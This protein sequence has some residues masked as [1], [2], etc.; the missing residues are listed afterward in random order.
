MFVNVLEQNEHSLKRVLHRCFLP[1]V[2]SFGQAV[3]DEKIFLE[4][5]QSETG[6]AC[7]GHVY[8]RIWTNCTIFIEDLP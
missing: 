3:S 6:I 5:D 4:N 7:R 8:L 2:G 1:N